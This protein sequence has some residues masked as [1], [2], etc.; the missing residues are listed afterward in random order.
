[1]QSDQVLNWT[2]LNSFP[3]P[4]GTRGER[5]SEAE[6]QLYINTKVSLHVALERDRCYFTRMAKFFDNLRVR[7]FCFFP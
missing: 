3:L 7:M 5:S 6:P 1:M 4:K 2:G